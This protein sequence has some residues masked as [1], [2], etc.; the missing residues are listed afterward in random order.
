MAQAPTI[1]DLIKAIAEWLAQL[2]DQEAPIGATVEFPVNP[3]EES[4]FV[5]NAEVLTAAT[6]EQSGLDWF[7]YDKYRPDA[8]GGAPGMF[9]PTYVIIER[10]RTVREFRKNQWG[11]PHLTAFQHALGPWMAGAP[12]VKFIHSSVVRAEVLPTGGFG[13]Q[14]FRNNH[15][16]TISD[17]ETGLVWLEDANALGKEVS[18]GEALQIAGQICS[19]QYGLQDGSRGGDWRVPNVNELESLLDRSNKSGPAI[20]PGVFKNLSVANYWTSTS[21]SAFPVL[22]WY[23]AMAVG[24]PVFDLKI[25][26]MRIWPVRGRSTRV[27]QTGLISC[28]DM[29]GSPIPCTGSGQ[30]A[31]KAR[32]SGLPLA[33]PRFQV[34]VTS[35]TNA[36]PD[37]TVTDRTTGLTWL[38]NGEVFGT[39]NWQDAKNAC[40]SLCHG[41]NGLSDGSR[42]GDWRLPDINELRSLEDY[43]EARPAI[44][45]DHPFFNVR[46]SLVWSSTEVASAPT[47]ARF[48]Y[49]GIG[50][51]VWDHKS[52]LMGVWPVKGTAAQ[53]YSR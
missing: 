19:G 6:R 26:T 28:W 41:Q 11:S 20:T 21:V 4:A 1:D 18:W 5:R 24:P 10:W 44:A 32:A 39:L 49:V 22:A 35:G 37:G 27:T 43:G 25:N 16:G 42:P 40:K 34:N 45:K 2:P 36:A 48:L 7:S 46:E 9:Q 15:D 30:D 50:S 17:T 53:S 23:M 3:T 12:Q 38:R 47:L 51:C 13:S 52:V 33:T 14:R 8:P 29:M 31:D